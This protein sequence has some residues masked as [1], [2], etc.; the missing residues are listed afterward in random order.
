MRLSGNVGARVAF[1]VVIF[2]SL[3]HAVDGIGRLLPNSDPERWR[4]LAWFVA[5]ALG[6]PAAAVILWPFFEGRF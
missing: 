3:L 5:C 4:A 6:L 1:S 2:A